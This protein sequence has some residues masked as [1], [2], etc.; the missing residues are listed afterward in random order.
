MKNFISRIELVKKFSG[1]SDLLILDAR[2][3]LADSSEEWKLFEA[4]YLK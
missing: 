1:T 3:E 4:N 2:A